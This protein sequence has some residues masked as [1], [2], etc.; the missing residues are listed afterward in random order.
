M[1][2]ALPVFGFI[3]ILRSSIQGMGNAVVSTLNGILE[4]VVRVL[5]T[6]WLIPYGSFH[7]LCY[8]NPTAWIMAALMMLGVYEFRIRRSLR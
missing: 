1:Q 2:L 5:W 8:V 7:Q 6:M 4:S 3:M